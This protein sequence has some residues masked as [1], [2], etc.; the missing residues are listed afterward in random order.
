M[1]ITLNSRV[2]ST[3]V[4]FT[5]RVDLNTSNAT[6]W[7]SGCT[8]VRFTNDA[9]NLSLPY[10]LDSDSSV[11]CGNATNLATFWVN[12]PQLTQNTT[13]YAY[14]GNTAAESGESS[15]AWSQAG[16]G[17]V[18]HLNNRSADYGNYTWEI[19][20]G[21]EDWG[22]SN[23][24]VGYCVYFNANN[25]FF[26][27]STTDF[28]SKSASTYSVWLK[29][30]NLYS[31]NAHFVIFG[32][33]NAVSGASG[34]NVIFRS[35]MDG[36]SYFR[37][38]AISPYVGT[39]MADSGSDVS[40]GQEYLAVTTN[41]A[42]TSLRLCRNGTFYTASS[43]SSSSASGISLGGSTAWNP[44]NV[45][46]Y[47]D[48][49]RIANIARSDDW[50]QAEHL[51]SASPGSVSYII[52]DVSSCRTLN[53]TRI[54]NITADISATTD[55]LNIT[56]S[57][58]TVWGNGKT[59]TQTATTNANYTGLKSNST[60]GNISNITFR[61]FAVG[62]A[63]SS[64]ANNTTLNLVTVKDAY[65]LNGTDTAQGSSGSC[66]YHNGSGVY[67]DSNGG[68]ASPGTNGTGVVGFEV[69]SSFNTFSNIVIQNITGGRGGN[70]G[71]GGDGC[72]YTWGYCGPPSGEYYCGSGGRGGDGGYPGEV[73]AFKVATDS[74]NSFTDIAI[75]TVSV[76]LGG[77]A[78]R[79]GY[80][81]GSG[82]SC[83]THGY[84]LW[85]GG[86]APA[87]A[88]ATNNS[89]TYGFS[90]LN[91]GANT[92]LRN[93]ITSMASSSYGFHLNNSTS[94][95]LFINNNTAQFY[96][97]AAQNISSYENVG[98]FPT[99]TSNGSDATTF[100][101]TSFYTGAPHSYWYNGT[102]RPTAPV[103]QS[104]RWT[105]SGSFNANETLMGY[106]NASDANLDTLTYYWRYW[107]NGAIN[108]SGSLG[109]VTESIERNLVNLTQ[110]NFSHNDSLILECWANDSLL[111]SSYNNSS[112]S[113]PAGFLAYFSPTPANNSYLYDA[114]LTVNSTVYGIVPT[115]CNVTLGNGTVYNMTIAGRSAISP[116]IEITQ[117][118]TNFTTKCSNG[119]VEFSIPL[120][121][122]TALRVGSSY[123]FGISGIRFTPLHGYQQNV[124]AV[125]ETSSL[126][127][128]CVNNTAGGNNT[129][130]VTAT[131]TIAGLTLKA[132]QFYN[133]SGLTTLSPTASHFYFAY[134]GT[135]F[136]D[137]MSIWVWADFNNP[138]PGLKYNIT[139]IG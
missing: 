138:A 117:N 103:L 6:L 35:A 5:A 62:V 11:F 113:V 9:E 54:Y 133:Q 34:S 29:A 22:T 129:V 121:N 85:G 77:T 41:V 115:V 101:N 93:N 83:Y 134:N 53:E 45:E 97:N 44:A 56:A 67:V 112:A 139:V 60:L 10:D 4:N 92:F 116:T 105:P 84:C 70:G 127:L 17:A 64:T 109:P 94:N 21:S 88:V 107:R 98:W 48:E 55:C 73:Y 52:I 124:L 63:L 57:S 23:C 66:S 95:L 42:A 2:N 96:S 39:A 51:Q 46:G 24:R 43:G 135:H 3:L 37:L 25:E 114:R 119:S 118:S 100:A 136:A 76:G 1:P 86:S 71:V 65:G 68:D 19:K 87:L 61:N 18:W 90:L 122:I 125:N 123:C 132:A 111:I 72:V 79:Q 13:I 91:G 78:G 14:L 80:G 131:P 16:Y 74:S 28:D 120:Y 47:Y 75:S 50:L 38:S 40:L 128:F 15:A 30:T 126:A 99:T 110:S 69:N 26:Y 8:N 106:C 27:S 102:L 89:S 36:G 58:V 59:I 104:V 81:T 33:T 108:A 12:V 7:G 49:A 20:S 31:N 130:Y 82:G 32:N 137:N